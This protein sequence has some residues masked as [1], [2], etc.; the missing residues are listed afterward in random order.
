VTDGPIEICGFPPFPQKTWKG[1]GT[2][3]LCRAI[4]V[5]SRTVLL[6]RAISALSS[7]GA[8]AGRKYRKKKN[9]ANPDG[10]A[11]FFVSYSQVSMK[12]PKSQ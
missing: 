7:Y 2:A 11:L 9:S 12:K 4:S 3:L 6:C 5:L 1:W 10:I 8:F